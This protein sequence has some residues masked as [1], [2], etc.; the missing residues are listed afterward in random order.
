LPPF[1][2]VRDGKIEYHGRRVS[3]AVLELLRDV[4]DHIDGC[5]R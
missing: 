2:G 3:P 5:A 4:P 1:T